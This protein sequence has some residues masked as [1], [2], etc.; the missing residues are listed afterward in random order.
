MAH[1]FTKLLNSRKIAVF[2]KGDC[3]KL[4]EAF[5]NVFGS[6]ANSS[7]AHV[8][9]HVFGRKCHLLIY[10]TY[11]GNITNVKM[12]CWQRLFAWRHNR[13][14]ALGGRRGGGAAACTVIRWREAISRRCSVRAGAVLRCGE[15]LRSPRDA[16]FIAHGGVVSLPWQ[17]SGSPLLIR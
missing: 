2:T 6:F 14:G 13:V 15:A 12:G 5:R 11:T 7:E 8:I 10:Y 17:E 4:S 3:A 16:F 1:D 9:S